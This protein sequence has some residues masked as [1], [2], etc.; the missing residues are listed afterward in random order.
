MDSEAILGLYSWAIGSC[1][2]CAR[3]GIETTSVGVL[4]PKDGPAQEIRA[5]KVCLLI[6]EGERAAGASR[7]AVPYEP[8]RIGPDGPPAS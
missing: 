3:T 2:Q 1:F 4:H 7:A 5:C 8:G 6:L